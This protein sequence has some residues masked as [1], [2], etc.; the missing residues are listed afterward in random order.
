MF[1]NLGERV[2]RATLLHLKVSRFSNYCCFWY[3]SLT[4]KKCSLIQHVQ[5]VESMIACDC[6]GRHSPCFSPLAHRTKWHETSQVPF[7][8]ATQGL[9]PCKGQIMA[10]FKPT[11]GFKVLLSSRCLP[12]SFGKHVHYWDTKNHSFKTLAKPCRTVRLSASTESTVAGFHHQQYHTTHSWPH[13]A[14]ITA[15]AQVSIV[16]SLGIHGNPGR[17]WHHS[18]PLN[19]QLVNVMITLVIHKLQLV[20]HPPKKK[21]T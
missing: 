17:L 19:P 2:I 12:P 3:V 8:Q 20:S 11:M 10:S 6:F 18:L 14:L 9:Q 13:G 1:D 5:D 21:I 16:E 7:Q 15:K 4:F